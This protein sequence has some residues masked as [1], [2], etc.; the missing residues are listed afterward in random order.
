MFYNII[1]ILLY[2]PVGIAMVFS[3]KIRAF[4]TKRI[5]QKIDIINNQN[6]IWIHCAS[7]GEVNLAEPIIRKILDKTDDNILITMVT[8]TGRGVAENKYKGNTRVEVL[9]F[10]LDD[11]FSVKKILKKICLKKLII[12]ETE[13][14]PNL[15]NLSSKKAK[16]ILI[17]GRISDKSINSYTKIKYFLKKLL[18]KIEVF[19]MQTEKDRHR[20]IFLGANE[21]KTFN[22]GNLKFNIEFPTYPKEKLEELKRKVGAKNKKIWV[23][24]STR[25]GE[26]EYILE[27][28][29]KLEDVLLIVVPR[30]IE[31]TGDICSRLL[32]KYDYIKWS[33]IEDKLIGESNEN[34]EVVIVDKIGELRKLYAIADLVY[35]G[36]TLV[37]VG[38]H[39][40]L[41]PLFY[42]KTP[43][44]GSYTQNVKEIAREIVDKKIGIQVKDEK[45]LLK[46]V[47]DTISTKEIKVE[48]ENKIDKFFAE[49]KDVI[50]LTFNKIK[51]V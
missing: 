49:N 36:G 51:E 20:I 9:Y 50:E 31:R 21:D 46:A 28:F 10:P 45:E 19:I 41:E 15:I 33:N 26:E 12:V 27:V 2:I 22:Y 35:V 48:V 29:D 6:V 39:S 4:V 24:G 18:G 32:Y 44:F 34:R 47:N 11:Y 40:L 30:H 42:R 17:N 43:I 23:A 8:D 16:I 7:V 25:E 5:F 38:G 37:D 13:I 1:R 3:S 14:W